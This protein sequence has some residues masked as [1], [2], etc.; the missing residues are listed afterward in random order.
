MSDT[1]KSK[2]NLLRPDLPFIIKEII[3][4]QYNIQ[5]E[6]KKYGIEGMIH[7]LDDAEKNLQYLFSA[8]EVDSNIL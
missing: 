8:I 1:T 6:F 2:I 4:K 3:N 5:P 7:S